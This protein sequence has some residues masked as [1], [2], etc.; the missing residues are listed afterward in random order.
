MFQTTNQYIQLQSI[1]SYVQWFTQ[2]K[3][4]YYH[5][6][7]ISPLSNRRIE[8]NILHQKIFQSLE[9]IFFY[10]FN[11]HLWWTC[12]SLWNSRHHEQQLARCKIGQ[13]MLMNFQFAFCNVSEMHF[14]IKRI[15]WGRWSSA[16]LWILLHIHQ[17]FSYYFSISKFH[18]GWIPASFHVLFSMC[19]SCL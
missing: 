9:L 5:M 16:S 7:E 19:S 10:M 4:T 14:Q 15:H 2:M 8:A 3:I 18:R 17:T 6:T 1:W 13:L 11:P 12:W